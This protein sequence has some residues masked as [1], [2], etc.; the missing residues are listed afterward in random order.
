MWS[1]AKTHFCKKPL[2]LS[3][4]SYNLKTIKKENT[5]GLSFV[6]FLMEKHLLS[7]AR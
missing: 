1:L 2:L 4:L 5:K 7:K 6:Y 3:S